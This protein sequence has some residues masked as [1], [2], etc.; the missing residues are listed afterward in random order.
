MAFSIGETCDGCSACARRCPVSAIAG[1]IKE[2]HA[3]VADLCID[4]GACGDVCRR[5]AI[6]DA[7]GQ[8]APR[9]PVD[10]RLRPVIDP[11][12]CNGCQ[13][14][15]D[16]CAFGCLQVAGARYQG[17]AVLAVA[18]ACVSCGDCATVCSKG[19]I[20]FAV[21]NACALPMKNVP[22]HIRDTQV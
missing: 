6:F 8:L 3:I 12:L 10:H 2:P 21:P 5:N 7:I 16:F 4:C 17:L 22:L 15:A 11:A 20:T 13:L 9:V 18:R 1:R 19:A 14:C